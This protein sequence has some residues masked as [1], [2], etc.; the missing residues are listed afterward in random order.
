MAQITVQ[1][2]D[3]AVKAAQVLGQ[4]KAIIEAEINKRAQRY[5][6][7]LIQMA[8]QKLADSKTIDELQA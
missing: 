6:K 8:K 7:Q 2:S 3:E 4:S 5:L 1:I